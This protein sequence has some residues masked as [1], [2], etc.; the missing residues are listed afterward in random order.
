MARSKYGNRKIV[1]ETHTFDSQAE[2][3]HYLYLLS[4]QNA[5]RI[6]ELEPHPT[7]ELLP[8]FKTAAG[9]WEQAVT[10]TPDFRYTE[11]SG[12]KP[13]TVC[14]DVKGVRTAVYIVKRKLFQ[15]TYPDILFR[16]VEV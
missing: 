12:D 15:Y 10:Y 3:Y 8:K 14:E 7:Y 5:G 11:Y 1:T 13:V 16:E 6:S 2:Y 9:K 4:E